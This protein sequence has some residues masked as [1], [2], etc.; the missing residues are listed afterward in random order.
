MD[1]K[2][3]NNFFI[4]LLYS[5]CTFKFTFFFRYNI[6]HHLH[7]KHM[8]V[9]RV[10]NKLWKNIFWFTY[11][12]GVGKKREGS[13]F[14]FNEQEECDRGKIYFSFVCYTFLWHTNDSLYFHTE[15][16][17][18]RASIQLQIAC[19]ENTFFFLMSMSLLVCRI[20]YFPIQYSSFFKEKSSK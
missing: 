11:R 6:L 18:M 10:L 4:A 5:N 19:K 8:R 12:R 2:I 17:R 16:D 1:I 7:V 13:K 20:F 15:R 14:V 9:S 3:Y